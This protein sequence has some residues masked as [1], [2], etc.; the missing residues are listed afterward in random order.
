V[1]NVII[2]LIVVV[3]GLG[4]LAYQESPE[5]ET[6]RMIDRLVKESKKNERRREHKPKRGYSYVQA[7]WSKHD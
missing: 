2:L 3:V 1:N 7:G 4:I 5:Y 6:N